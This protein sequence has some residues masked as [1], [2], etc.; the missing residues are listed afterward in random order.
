MLWPIALL[1]VL[2]IRQVRSHRLE[3]R[4][5]LSDWDA[6]CVRFRLHGQGC[7]NTR[8]L[9]GYDSEGDSGADQQVVI[10]PFQDFRAD[11]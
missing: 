3:S 8:G 7:R 10:Y 9:A 5:Q 11:A 1:H 4:L 2:E 6:T